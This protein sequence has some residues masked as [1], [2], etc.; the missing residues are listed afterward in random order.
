MSPSPDT[1]APAIVVE[2]LVKRYAG[3]QRGQV[4]TIAVN[5]VS[6]SVAPGTSFGI[7]GESGSG[8]STLARCLLGL[9]PVQ[10]GRVS[11]LG[12]EITTA[13]GRDLRRWRRDMQIV[14]QE[15]YEALDP[16]MRIG[17]AIAE[18]LLLNRMAEPGPELEAKVIESMGLVALRPE[19]YDRLPHELSGGQQ[20]RVNIAR[21]LSTNPSVVILD[22]PTASLDVSVRAEVLRLLMRIQRERNLTYV[23]ISHDLATVRAICDRVGV[24]YLGRLLE[25]GPTEQVLEHPADPYTEFLLRSELSLDPDVH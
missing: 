17:D 18:P 1:A 16:R 24:M 2:G 10:S 5:D 23:L 14:F 20:Q 6:F 22:E 7:V 25:E 13:R 9:V 8:K 4:E 3:R 15:P 11:I 19:M 12:R 21:A